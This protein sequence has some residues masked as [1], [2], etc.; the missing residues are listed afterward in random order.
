[1]KQFKLYPTQSLHSNNKNIFLFFQPTTKNLK[2]TLKSFIEMYRANNCIPKQISVFFNIFIFRKEIGC[3]HK[4]EQVCHFSWMLLNM[5]LLVLKIVKPK[6]NSKSQIQVP[7][8]SHKF[9]SKKLK[10][11][12][13][14]KRNG[15]GADNI[16]LQATTHHPPPTPNFSHL[17]FDLQTSMRGQNGVEFYQ[18]STGHVGFFLALLL[19]DQ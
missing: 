19:A 4:A 17:K 5:Y 14:R 7:N 18:E 12:V 16:I 2:K 11:K 1:M 9:K 13:Q 8:P 6:S 15:T 3:S 10:S